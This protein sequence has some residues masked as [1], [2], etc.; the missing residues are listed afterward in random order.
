[1]VRVVLAG[2]AMA[3]HGRDTLDSSLP[4]S[5]FAAR[6]KKG[7]LVTLAIALL[8]F[9]LLLLPGGLAGERRALLRMDPQ[10]RRVLYDETRR[11][12]EAIC[13][14][15]ETVRALRDRCVDSAS[16]LLAFPECDEECQVFAHAHQLQPTR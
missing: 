1:M 6:H 7:L 4:A 2:N 5:S 8:G 13:S 16:F 3:T 15:S 9:T 11:N 10:E 14:Q 12:A